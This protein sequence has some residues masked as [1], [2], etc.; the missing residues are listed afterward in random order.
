MRIRQWSAVA[1]VAYGAALCMAANLVGAQA[2]QSAASTDSQGWVQLKSQ[3][4]DGVFV[5]PG[6]DFRGY[7]KVMLDPTQA[8]MA[9]TW[10]SDMNFNPVFL[11]NRTT[12]RDGEE[13]VDQARAGFDEIFAKAL[14]SAGYELVSSPGADVLRLSPR[15]IDLY[16]RAPKSVTNSLPTMRVRTANPGEATLVLEARD[17]TT[18]ALLQRV[19]D[20][21][22]AGLQG[23]FGL[24]VR[25][26]TPQ[27][28][29]FGFGNL[30]D[31]W[32]QG[33]VTGLEELKARSPIAIA[34][35]AP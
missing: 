28:N 8:A 29:R 30:F 21:R 24:S 23:N 14:R 12:A 26:T 15:V 10:L 6:A 13:I 4:F 34:Q 31:S 22:T 2:A 32:A 33:Y 25:N 19:V 7:S 17:S 16:V 5:L 20:R 35:T 1:A 11:L 3:R 27:T 18:G 9:K